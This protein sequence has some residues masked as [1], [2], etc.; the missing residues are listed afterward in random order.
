MHIHGEILPLLSLLKEEMEFV[1]T[2]IQD[3]LLVI[4]ELHQDQDYFEFVTKALLTELIHW[5][6]IYTNNE[7]GFVEFYGNTVFDSISPKA[8]SL[9]LIFLYKMQK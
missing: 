6:W 8:N 5:P 4:Q 7:K 3:I 2:V 1:S 9:K